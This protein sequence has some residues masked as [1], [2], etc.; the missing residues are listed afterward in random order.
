MREFIKNLFI[1]LFIL[2]CFDK[3]FYF[4]INR[5]AFSEVDKRLEMIIKGQL[6]KDILILGSSRGARDIVAS[7]IE[8][9][10]EQSTYNIAYPGS[11]ITFHE[12]ILKTL[13]KYESKPKIILLTI[14]DDNPSAF[15]PKQ[16]INFRYDRLYPLTKYDYINNELIERKNTSILSKYFY[17]K[18]KNALKFNVKQ[19]YFNKLDTILDCGSMPISFQQEKVVWKY[20]RNVKI[21][22][23]KSEVLL[24]I[25]SFKNFQKMCLKENI[26]LYIIIPPN[27]KP[28][29]YN[30]IQRI[31][32]LTNTKFPIIIYDNN[33]KK[34]LDNNYFY[35]KDH[36]NSK[37]AI[38][39]T[40]EIIN[41]LKYE[42]TTMY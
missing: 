15:M 24:K 2:F 34:Y 6:K 8:K 33:E 21:Y 4:N 41:F 14:D 19:K 42:N 16:S 13:I 22:N 26:N 12:F 39:F 18:R 10:L 20:K 7:Q 5:T 3:L 29:D 9:T 11:D 27:Y 28:L 31:K 25:E 1:F 23:P 38:I 35:N 32:M 17:L 40:N 36:L 37:G 30:F